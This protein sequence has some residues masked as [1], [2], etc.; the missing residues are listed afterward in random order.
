LPERW[1]KPAEVLDVRNV[2]QGIWLPDGRVHGAVEM[3]MSEDT[4]ERMRLGY[5]CAKCLE[6]F[7][8]PWP[9]RCHVCGAP[10]RD[11]QAEYFAQEFAGEVKL[12]ST[13]PLDDGGMWERIERERKERPL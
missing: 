10:V 13:Q 7:E 8:H 4:I 1:R 12:G 3:T 11:K 9:E 5:L 6:P 2:H